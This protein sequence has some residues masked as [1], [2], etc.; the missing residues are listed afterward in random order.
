M[1]LVDHNNLPT[2]ER[3]RT[4]GH[5]I[6]SPVRAENQDIRGLHIGLLNMMPDAAIE[7]TERQ[8]FRLVSSSNPISQFYLHPF[9]LDSIPRGEAARAHID[10]YYEP[11]ES[12]QR[13]GLDA[14]I[15]SG[16]NVTRPNLSE[17]VFWDQLSEVFH[18]ADNHVTSTLCS[19]LATHALLLSRY[20][21]QRRGLAKK[22]WGVFEH[23]V[24]RREHPLVSNINTQLFVPHSRFND[25]SR[26][27]MD[28]VGLHILIEG[29]EPGVQL[30]V[31]PDGFRT[32]F[33]Q[34]HPEYD[35]ISLMKEYKR[36]VGLYFDQKANV[37]P[38]VPK[39]YFDAFT[40]ALLEEYKDRIVSNRESGT[41]PPLFPENLIRPRIHNKWHDSGEALIGNWIGMVYQ[42]TNRKRSIPYMDGID[43]DDPLGWLSG[44]VSRLM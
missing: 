37:Y 6:L 38:P 2:F 30:A 29:K 27:Q 15:V 40:C 26:E 24:V 14:L 7:A 10:Q 20:G 9:T 16:A 13:K 33:F 22:C 21:V 8:F 35:A 28:E 17:E 34:G 1:P 4:E 5:R 23:E 41:P 43:R 36:D 44:D 18:W 3:L 19:C 12:I 32:V 39:H 31:S 11:Y 42:I 25:I